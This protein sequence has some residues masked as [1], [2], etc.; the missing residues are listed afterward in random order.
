MKDLK[1]IPSDVSIIIPAFN[2]EE[3]IEQ[4]VNSIRSEFPEGEIVVVDDGSY[5]NTAVFAEKAGATVI[6]KRENQGYGAAIKTGILSSKSDYVVTFDADGQHN[7]KDIIR[8]LKFVR[9]NDMVIGIREKLLH[10]N[11]W[12][13]PGKW[14]LVILASYLVGKRIPDLN[15][16]LRVMH[17]KTVLKYL[18]LCPSGFSFSTTITMTMLSRNYR[19]AYVPIDVKR[20]KGK[21]T[22][23]LKTGMDT[24]IL[25]IRISTLFN[26]LR[27]FLP[28]SILM[29]II[30]I[31]CGIPGILR[32]GVTI[33]IHSMLAIVS[34][35]MLF[36]IGLLSDQISQMR[37]EH[38]EKMG[39]SLEDL[40]LESDDE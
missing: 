3:T 21:S 13:M 23:T 8:I 32:E 35:I 5:D 22:V 37:L 15:S 30:G 25:I 11:L 34:G 28:I 16:G 10:S 14:L 12:R 31:A 2:E 19:V 1:N 24:L 36:G 40:T 18:H 27:I 6:R 26:P 29:W 33:G 17:R 9:N 39:L 20:R 4:V 38:F 7:V